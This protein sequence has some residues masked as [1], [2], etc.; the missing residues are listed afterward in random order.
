MVYSNKHHK[1]SVSKVMF[2]HDGMT[3]FSMSKDKY[4]HQYDLRMRGVLRK[5]AFEEEPKDMQFTQNML[6]VGDNAGTLH[7]FDESG[8]VV[9]KIEGQSGVLAMA[10]D[11]SDNW[12]VVARKDKNMFDLYGRK[13]DW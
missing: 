6:V 5:Y 4:I 1:D 9:R 10:I 2:H 8:G 7:F 3:Y 12:M 13:L 11:Q